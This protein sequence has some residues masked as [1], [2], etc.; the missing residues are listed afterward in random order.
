M[1]SYPDISDYTDSVQNSA[2]QVT[3]P[4]LLKAKPRLKGNKPEMMSGGCAVVYP[5]Q[6]GGDIY[7][8]KCWLRD[9][10]DL[11]AHYRL[12]ESFLNSCQST[13][14]VG[15]AYV[16]KGIIAKDQHWP[17][18]RM[19]WV[20]GKSVL[21]FVS[22]NVTDSAALVRLAERYLAM[23]QQ[24]HSLGVAH[25]DLQGSNI[26]VI[27]SGTSIDFQLIDYDTLIVPAV[28]G[29]KA[30]AS[31]LPS[32]QHPKRGAS[33]C[34]SGKEDYFSELVIYISLLAVAEKP[35]MWSNYPKGDPGLKDEDRHDKDVLFVKEDFVSA[36]PTEVFKELFSLSPHVKRLTLILW[37]Y[38]RTQSI[39]ELLPLEEAVRIAMD[40]SIVT[41]NTLRYKSAFADLLETTQLAMDDWLDDSAFVTKP[42]PKAASMIASGNGSTASKNL[43]FEELVR[44]NVP[45]PTSQIEVGNNSTSANPPAE[46]WVGLS[47]IGGLIAVSLILL[48]FLPSRNSNRSAPYPRPEREWVS[49]ANNAPYTQQNAGSTTYSSKQT[50]PIGTPLVFSK[51]SSSPDGLR[52]SSRTSA[53]ILARP[54]DGVTSVPSQP[55]V[56][57]QVLSTAQPQ[58]LMSISDMDRSMRRF[59]LSEGP[60][61]MKNLATMPLPHFMSDSDRAI[62]RFMHPDPS[63]ALSVPPW[64]AQFSFL[65]QEW[66]PLSPTTLYE[67]KAEL[68]TD[69]CSRNKPS[70]LTIEGV[71]A[72][73]L[74]SINGRSLNNLLQIYASG[75]VWVNRSLGGTKKS[76][77]EANLRQTFQDWPRSR[78]DL[79]SEPTTTLA[80]DGST[81]DVS[82]RTRFRME[83]SDSRKWV[84]G[85]RNTKWL[86]VHDQ[87]WQVS[88][89][90]SSL[91]M[92]PFEGRLPSEY[93]SSDNSLTPPAAIEPP[94]SIPL[95]HP[96]TPSLF[97]RVRVINVEPTDSLSLRSGPGSLALK[98][99]D[100]PFDAAGIE[101]IGENRLNGSD[102][103]VPVRWNGLSGW[104]HGGHVDYE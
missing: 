61:W 4:S 40:S 25:G 65:R 97:G 35:S 89:E 36:R 29:R 27:G 10:G 78:V 50:D 63:E 73:Y 47:L 45:S 93:A 15:F 49:E 67:T 8:V 81:A 5:F 100:I 19:K 55:V 99:A 46:S 66:K 85:T 69:F 43:S 90:E 38:T 18:L 68:I 42:V 3:D 104:V 83:N 92:P 13:Y 80:D 2:S 62:A 75:A 96:T 88:R 33:R 91:V 94:V 41:T 6:D 64:Y 59:L 17:F 82:F 1:P 71:I 86:L 24:L 101:I 58:S 16:E 95:A 54:N 30:E 102:T 84:E 34:Y 12:V 23:S 31:A 11:R 28:H 53:P 9:I 77:F 44:L 79:A 76:T 57:P 48:V 37:N 51:G 98:L 60:L 32:Y 70:K 26:K 103:W 56:S 39:E 22:A 20:G 7:A 72:T 52:T 74:E 87:E 14:F 21:E